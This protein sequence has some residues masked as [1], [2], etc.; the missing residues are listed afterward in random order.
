MI[1]VYT[2]TYIYKKN[3]RIDLDF[4]KE[5][6]ELGD[7]GRFIIHVYMYT[8]VNRYLT[9][10]TPIFTF[11]FIH[12]CINTNTNIFIAE[13]VP[14]I[15][16]DDDEEEDKIKEVSVVNKSHNIARAVVNSIMPWVKVFLLKDEKDHK[17][18]KSKTVRPVV[19]LALTKLISRYVYVYIHMSICV[20]MYTYIYICKYI[21]I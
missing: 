8:S 18:N 15:D 4:N 17:G 14:E 5:K 12:I 1:C 10:I 3:N 6:T 7:A 19:A 11:A 16:E 2:Y 20:C 13:T 9:C 21:H